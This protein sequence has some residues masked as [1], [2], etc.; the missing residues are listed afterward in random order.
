MARKKSKYY[1]RP[2]GIHEAIR[3]IDG[4]R[5][6]FR[7][8][9]DAEVERKM[10]LWRDQQKEKTRFEKV[11]DEWWADHEPTLEYNTTKSY[12]PAIERAKVHFGKMLVSDITS[13]DIDVYIK[14]FSKADRSRKV[15][16]TQLQIIRQ[17]MS[18]AVLRGYIAVNPAREVKP[19]RNLPKAYRLP[20]TRDEIALI[21]KFKEKH[22][23]PFLI[24]ETGC[25]P[26]EAF[27]LRW[28]DIDRDKKLIH[29]RRSV[30]YVGTSPHIKQPKTA[31][32]IRSVPL[33]DALDAVL[34]KKFPKG[35]IFTSDDGKSL[36][37]SMTANR[38]YGAFREESGVKCT[39]YQIRHGYATALQ[40]AGIDMKVRQILLGHAQISTTM[41]I[42]THIRED[43]LT[44]AAQAM[45]ASF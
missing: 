43:T 15:V 11:A 25:R 4:K 32:G 6:A 7:G 26:G 28:E 31:S 13:D 17:I 24:Y 27:A 10:I 5:V 3:V 38:L 39:A 14:D 21:K 36:L 9:S 29:I 22:L 41:D 8:R 45:N 23:L 34:P 2:D 40:E 37:P 18:F 1:V 35:Y 12:A 16:T 33:L 19:P 44:D 42:Y 30:Y 20:P